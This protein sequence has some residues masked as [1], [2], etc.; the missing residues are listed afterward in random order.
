MD[1]F[2]R[3]D[4]RAFGF[5]KWVEPLVGGA[6]HRCHGL[7][8]LAGDVPPEVAKRDLDGFPRVLIGRGASDSWYTE[9]KLTADVQ[10]LRGKGVEVDFERFDG[11]HEWTADFRERCRR[12]L[13]GL[14]T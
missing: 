5:P 11:G 10:L 2:R 6:G 7:I 9:E 3:G 8:A 14:D 4:L 1:G 12:F 13:T